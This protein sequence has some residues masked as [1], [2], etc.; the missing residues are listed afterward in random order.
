M[1]EPIGLLPLGVT[2]GTVAEDFSNWVTCAGV[3]RAL[4]SATR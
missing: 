2:C 3:S 4:P 1:P